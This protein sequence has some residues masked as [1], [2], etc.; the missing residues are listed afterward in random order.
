MRVANMSAPPPAPQPP[1]GQRFMVSFFYDADGST[2]YV[3]ST[4]R[5]GF[6][7]YLLQCMRALVRLTAYAVVIYKNRSTFFSHSAS[8]RQGEQHDIFSNKNVYSL[9]G[10]LDH[11][12]KHFSR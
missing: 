6:G 12:Y 3:L 1:V 8:V 11:T 5:C 2:S 4:G 9:S 7:H 10:A